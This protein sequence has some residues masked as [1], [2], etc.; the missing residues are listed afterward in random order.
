[1]ITPEP[2][3]LLLSQKTEREDLALMLMVNMSN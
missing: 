3:D 2:E 1:M